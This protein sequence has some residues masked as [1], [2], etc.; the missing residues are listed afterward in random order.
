MTDPIL[1]HSLPWPYP[2]LFAHRGGGSHAPENTLGAVKAGQ[3]RGYIAFEFDVKLSGD[4]VAMLMHD[5]TLERTTNGKGAVAVM[6]MSALEKL[7]A[8][9]WHSDAFRGEL[10]PRFSTVATY[11]HAHGLMANVEIK[12]CEQRDVETGKWVGEMCAELWRDR[13]VKPLISSFSVD[14]LRAARAAAPDLPMG[15]LVKIPLE[16]HLALLRDL[17]CVSIHCHHARIDA[18]LVRF[19]HGHG[20]RVLTYT[21]NDVARLDALL[22]IGVDGVFTD[23]LELMAQDN[24]ELLT[25]AG[26]PMRDALDA[27]DEWRAAEPPMP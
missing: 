15:L 9:A 11:L 1:R 27:D 7:D 10:V 2:T 5:S 14:A 3:A 8:G 23:A 21:V 18:A 19:F 26:R 24:A 4:G 12:P 22:A 20:Y 16:S 17:G 6:N 13:L 25:D